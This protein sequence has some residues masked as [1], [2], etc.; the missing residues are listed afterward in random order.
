MVATQ[1]P[2]TGQIYNKKIYKPNEIEM[3]LNKEYIQICSDTI[4]WTNVTI[5]GLF[6][7][8]IL[9]ITEFEYFERWPN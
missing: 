6:M 9:P 8:Q 5:F 7:T 2:D 3:K 4:N 1:P